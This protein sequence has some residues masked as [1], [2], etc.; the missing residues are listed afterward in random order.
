MSETLQAKAEK[1]ASV[2]SLGCA[3]NLVDSEMMIPQLQEIG[4]RMTSDTSRASLLLVNTCGFLESAVEEAIETILSLSAL[5]ETGACNDLIVTGCMV[6]R[7]GKKLLDLLPE[8]DLFLGTSHYHQLS[9]ILQLRREGSSQKLWISPPRHIFTS[10]E[11]RVRSTG[12]FT[13]Y[14]KIAEGCSNHCTFCLIPHLRGPYR[15]RTVEDILQEAAH[16]ASGGVKEINVIAQDTTA[17][18]TDRGEQAGL[19]HLLEHLDRIDGIEWVRVL[20]AYPDRVDDLLLHTMA[21]ASKVVPYLDI[22]FQH[23][24]PR[25]LK[26]MRRGGSFPDVEEVIH[27]I[28]HHIPEIAL[29]T[30]LMVGFPGETEAEFK[31]LLEFME[32]VQFDHVGGFAFSPEPGS[33]AARLP[34]QVPLEL[35]EER[36]NILHDLQR[37]ISRRRL[38][39]FIGETLP[40]LIEGPHPETDLLL[41]ARLATQAPEV[42]GMVLITS[43]DAQMGEITRARITAA[44]EYDLEAEIVSS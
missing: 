26:E 37:D 12:S 19:A 34:S 29:R 17:F 13:A 4:Y 39:R 15:S 8:V 44:H 38:E 6:Q 40:V 7:Y 24:A 2:V 22:P 27:R 35:R 43:G 42:D 25:I 11:P 21:R 10:S 16:M 20:Y 32:R 41:A 31:S 28:R 33:R 30:S 14:L 1:F 9:H 5:K 18:G 36:L 23:C 3:K